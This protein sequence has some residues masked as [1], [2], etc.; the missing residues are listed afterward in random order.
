MNEAVVQES[1]LPQGYRNTYKKA[2]DAVK[3]GNHGY[4]VELL[5]SVVK[6]NPSFLDGR[7]LLRGAEV[8]AQS[9]KKG[10]FI[11]TTAVKIRKPQ[12]TLKK[13]PLAAIYEVEEIL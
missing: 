1:E 11:D 7:K 2:V 8:Q 5:L 9:G 12:A 13:D 6:E 4:A 3:M 10:K